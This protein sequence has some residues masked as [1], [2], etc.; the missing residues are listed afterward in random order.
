[1]FRNALLILGLLICSQTFSNEKIVFLKES[2]KGASLTVVNTKTKVETL[3]DVGNLNVIYPTISTDGKLLAFSGSKDQREWAIFLY[4]LKSKKMT[5]VIPANGLTIQPSFSG[6]THKMAFTAPVE[7]KNQ[8]HILDFKKWLQTK[9]LSIEVIKTDL[10]AYYPYMSSGGF[11]V[12]FH[13]SHKVDGKSIQEIAM[14]NLQEKKLTVLKDQN[15]QSLKGKAPCFNLDDSKIAYVTSMGDDKWAVNEFN[16]DNKTLRNLT[17]G[18]YKDYSP[19]YISN[20]RLLFSSNR[21]G[22]FKF[23]TREM[24]SQ[25]PNQAD[26]TILH[27]S[28][29]NIWDPR[30]SGDL[31]YKQKQLEN[32]GGEERSSFGAVSVGDSIY[33]VGGHKG[34]EHTYPPESF[35]KE[36]YRYDLKS[37]SWTRLADKIS[38]VHGVTISYYNGYIYAFGG[39]AYSENYKP[40]WKSLKTIERYDIARNKWEVIGELPEPRSSN[41]IATIGSKVYLIGGWDATPK[42]I[43][44]KDGTFHQSVVIYDMK[45]ESARYALF[46]VPA[47]AR[48]AFTAA[49]RDGHII[50]GGGI[51]QGGRHFDMLDEV[52]SINPKNEILWT[53]LPSLPFANFAPAMLSLDGELHMFGGMKLTKTGYGYVNHVYKLDKKKNKWLHTGRFLKERKGFIQPVQFKN[54][55][56][57][58]GGHTYD[59]V[60]KD[61]PVSTFE[62]FYRK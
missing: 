30:A 54:Y 50:I 59:R 23:Y 39:F 57:L 52:W 2:D 16:I 11:N 29:S 32:I 31:S 46:E 6:N 9:E 60:G 18:E 51:T 55:A 8:I 13:Q 21:S 53:R 12:T 42:H 10:P 28:E 22:K 61:G 34:F 36:V 37:N 24:N 48:R 49:T 47:K 26:L 20:G 15:G 33:V 27:E 19:R 7:G 38:P 56:G 17:A 3:I 45:T 41:A 25:G 58:L 1:M 4:D 5:E 44:D 14:Y 35:S 43:G 40:K 62:I